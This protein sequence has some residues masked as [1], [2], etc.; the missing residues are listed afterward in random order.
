MDK[1]FLA[2]ASALAWLATA[3]VSVWEYAS[4]DRVGGSGAPYLLRAIC[5]VTAV[6]LTALWAWSISEEGRSS[7]WRRIGAAVCILC[8]LAAAIVTWAEMIWI[9]LLVIGLGSIAASNRAERRPLLTVAMALLVGGGVLIAA[10]IAG[11]GPRD[12]H[13][14]HPQSFAIGVIATALLAAAAIAFGGRR[15]THLAVDA[16]AASQRI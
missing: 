11:I 12:E 1:G 15:S 7:T 14:D 10:I 6:A 16:G 8:V 5:A 3:A 13:G 2:R 9:T 4:K